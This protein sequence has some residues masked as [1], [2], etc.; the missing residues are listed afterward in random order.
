MRRYAVL[1]S[2]LVLVP[3]AGAQQKAP[4]PKQPP[5][6]P[7]EGKPEA[8]P[9]AESQPAPAAAPTDLEVLRKE[10]EALRESLFTSRARAAAVG[11]ALYSA[12]VQV[13]LRYV[14]GRF[15]S[16]RRA[17]IR[18]DGSN[19]YDDTAGAIAADEAPRFEGFVAPG[20]HTVT[21]RVEA[22]AKDDDRFVTTTEDTFTLD[23]P[24]GRMLIVKA[25]ADDGGD[26][27]YAWKKKGKGGYRLKLDVDVESVERKDVV[28]TVGAKK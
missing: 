7:P 17:T 18:L 25:R 9:A 26:M 15:Q 12:K 14:S 10:Y 23:A 27:A 1:V 16:I 2:L 19:V 21:V 24:A 20:A 22:Q 11:D 6:A 28:K 3:L 4:D 5:P 8:P 13:H